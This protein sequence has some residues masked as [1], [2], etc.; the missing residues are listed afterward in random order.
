LRDN[1]I[2]PIIINYLIDVPSQNEI[3]SLAKKFGKRPAEFVRKGEKIFKE[4]TR[5]LRGFSV[6]QYL[7]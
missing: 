6:K 1:S 7:K 2:E 5:L 3:K 4:N